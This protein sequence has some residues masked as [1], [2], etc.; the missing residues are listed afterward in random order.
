MKL[1]TEQQEAYD[2]IM[3]LA[4]G[5][6]I[7]I[8]GEAGTGKSFTI[9]KA[10]DTL[11]NVLKCAPSGI[12]AT[13]IHGRTFHKTFQLHGALYLDRDNWAERRVKLLE[14]Y[15]GNFKEVGKIMA[16]WMHKSRKEILVAANAIWVD[17][18]PT[19]RCDLLDEAD[20][21]LRHCLKKPHV[22]FGGMRMIFSGDLGQL[23]PVVT[24]KE[25][26]NLEAAGYCKPFGFKQAH[27]FND[28]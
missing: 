10:C 8:D 20:V 24:E 28:S 23:Q 22:P 13:N 25:V 3:N 12:A 4:G 6:C 27:V 2:A 19:L 17:E 1:S 7:Y 26:P 14:K 9:E 16:R 18:A 11:G 15:D 5:E 21:R